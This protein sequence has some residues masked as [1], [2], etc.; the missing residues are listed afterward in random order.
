[1]FERKN[2]DFKSRF[3]GISNKYFYWV[4][5]ELS[6]LI[7]GLLYYRKGDKVRILLNLVNKNRLEND[8]ELSNFAI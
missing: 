8:S 3:V 6:V 2:I 1:M 5:I 4:K 7:R